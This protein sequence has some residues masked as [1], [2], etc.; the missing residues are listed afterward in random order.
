MSVKGAIAGL[1]RYTVFHFDRE[2][3]ML[4]MCPTYPAEQLKT[5]EAAHKM[6]V[7][8]VESF[9]KNFGDGNLGSVC[10]LVTGE[11]LTFLVE[12]LTNHIRGQN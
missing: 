7:D 1:R 8:K 4:K 2:I 6:F 3:E 9:E 11:M 5:H 12:W 10:E